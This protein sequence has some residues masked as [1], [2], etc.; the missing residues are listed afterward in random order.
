M[1]LDLDAAC[2]QD[3]GDG[4]PARAQPRSPPGDL[5]A[6][7]DLI[8]PVAP[9][10]E[11]G[12]LGVAYS[13]G[14]DSTALLLAALTWARPRARPVLA[15]TIDHGAR[16]GSAAEAAAAARQAEFWGA[17]A[18]TARVTMAGPFSQARARAAR[19]HTLARV[20]AAW[21]VR[22][23]LLGHTAD[24]QAETAL[25]RAAR[26]PLT[27]RGLAGLA[28][29]SPSPV[30][31]EGADL[32]LARPLLGVRRGDVRA[33]LAARG[34]S[35][36]DEPSNSDH[37]YERV[38]AR[39]ALAAFERAGGEVASLTAAA[40]AARA[41]EQAL[42][43]EAWAAVRAVCPAACDAVTRA[44]W[45]VDRAVYGGVA[46][47]ARRRALEAL[48]HAA[49]GRLAPV[50]RTALER[51]DAAL[52]EPGFAG[53]TLAGARLRR[54]G[55]AVVLERDPGALDG[56]R[57]HGGIAPL[58]LACGAVG[59]WD[60]RWRLGPA[61]RAGAVRPGPGGAPRFIDDRGQ[62]HTIAW[63]DLR[64]LLVARCLHPDVP[65]RWRRAETAPDAWR[66]PFGGPH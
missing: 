24:D 57:D 49:A 6:L 18:V 38:R 65:S 53:A 66:A 21:G 62:V 1:S 45:R 31:P 11:G 20:C 58:A 41:W 64:P 30:W 43:G 8:T 19:H 50:R 59:V 10:T 3:L 37:R 46:T 35:W 47:A 61:P 5:K 32:A 2:S 33:L 4:A 9:L 29:V 63:A 56:R 52:L 44:A 13:G 28:S 22:L 34:V 7:S 14:G 23:L 48:I 36:I 40:A 60:G 12:P 27:M 51:V 39:R 55:E 54:M 42:S 15:V 26:S 17:R 25:M 16:P